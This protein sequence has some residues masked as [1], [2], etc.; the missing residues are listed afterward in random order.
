MNLGVSSVWKR[1][2]AGKSKPLENG[3]GFRWVGKKTDV[4]DEAIR[5]VFEWFMVN[6]EEN[7]PNEVYEV[8]FTSTPYVLRMTK[9][10]KAEE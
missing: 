8:R 4:T 7:E 6:F 10:P 9:E 3:R 1:I 2:Y 5:A